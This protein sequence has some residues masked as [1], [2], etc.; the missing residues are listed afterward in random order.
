[1]VAL[2]PESCHVGECLLPLYLNGKLTVGIL[3]ASGLPRGLNGKESAYQSRDMG[4]IL[5]SGRSLGEGNGNPLQFLA[6]E[7][8]RTEEPGSLQVH[9]VMKELNTT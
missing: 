5:G 6:W 7:I 2:L 3:L 4:M 9:G 8:P 1:M